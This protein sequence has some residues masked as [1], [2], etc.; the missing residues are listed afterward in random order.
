MCH[1]N[2]SLFLARNERMDEHELL[3]IYF[4]LSYFRYTFLNMLHFLEY[5][6]P[7]QWHS[8]VHKHIDL[9]NATVVTETECVRHS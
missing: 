8:T 7:A 5:Y 1:V 4:K 6:S 2:V 3:S 9:S